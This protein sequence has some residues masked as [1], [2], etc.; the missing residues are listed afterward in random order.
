[1]KEAEKIF[2][3][4]SFNFALLRNKQEIGI[5]NFAFLSTSPI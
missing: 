3:T 4:A 1:M 5:Q 2:F